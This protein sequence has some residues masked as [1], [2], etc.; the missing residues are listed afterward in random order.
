MTLRVPD[1][2]LNLDRN[3]LAEF[4]INFARFEYAVKAAG[5]S[6]N[7]GGYAEPDWDSYCTSLATDFWSNTS[8][9]LGP[10]LSYIMYWHKLCLEVSI[11]LSSGII[12]VSTFGVDR[13]ELSNSGKWALIGGFGLAVVAGTILILYAAKLLQDLRGIL[14]RADR[15]DRLFEV[16]AYV[17]D[18][19]LYP[20]DWET[21][22]AVRMDVLPK[23]A[24]GLMV[25]TWVG[26]SALLLLQK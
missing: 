10:H 23:W 8:P 5:F 7:K 26:V 2:S 13:A 24:I 18:H 16:G 14:V 11:L 25:V 12:A 19:P 3:D 17:P 21:S 4:M 1:H 20:P 6:K 15:H 22:D 9:E